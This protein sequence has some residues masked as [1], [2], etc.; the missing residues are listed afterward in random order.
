MRLYAYSLSWICNLPPPLLDLLHPVVNGLPEAASLGE[1]FHDF[2]IFCIAN[3][4]H[5]DPGGEPGDR[6]SSIDTLGLALII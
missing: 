6:H 5:G 1:F 4:G 2:D 3:P